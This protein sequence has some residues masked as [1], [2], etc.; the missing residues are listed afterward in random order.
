MNK[1]HEKL[2]L[3]TNTD[4]IG[5]MA[6]SG[7]V[8][9][10]SAPFRERRWVGLLKF[11]VDIM[12]LEMSLCLGY[13]LRQAFSSLFP[14]SRTQGDFL[15]LSLGMLIVPIGYWLVR[16]YPGYGLTAVERL[17]RR[18]RATFVMFVVCIAWEYLVAKAG[19][20]SGVF[21]ATFVFAL[22]L[23]PIL[24]GLVRNLL[25]RMNCWGSPVLVFGGAKTGEVVLSF[26]RNDISLGL[27]PVGVID[28]DQDKWGTSLEGVPVIGGVEC[29]HSYVDSV[30]Y[31]ILAMPGAGRERLVSLASALPFPHI[32][33]IPDL[34]G[35]PSLWVEVRDL[36]GTMGLQIK[37]DL[38][39]RHNCY[40]KR[41]MDFIL[42][43][44]LFI[45][46]LPILA[47]FALWIKV[48]S[49]GPA[50]FTQEREGYEGKLF[51]IWKLRT[52]YLDAEERLEGYLAKN[53][54]A[55][56]EWNR[57]Y[58]LKNDPRI[59]P[60]VGTILRKTSLD[61]LPQLWNILKGEMSLVGPRPF[62]KYHLDNFSNEF[63]SM[64]RSVMPGLTGLWQVSARSDGDLDIQESLDSYYIRNWSIWMD[65]YLLGRT[66][67][68]V[69]TGRGAY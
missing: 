63:C 31:A 24:Q 46:S 27:K 51:R 10:E 11:L 14:I 35:L 36:G 2:T 56:N 57:F 33:I 54:A 16:L 20:S 37:K 25:I 9:K 42:G 64:R 21:L 68:I 48:A 39:L 34:L 7:V 60:M 13:E 23:P 65:L 47:F 43:I 28:D 38:L 4:C 67:G 50:F 61:E 59:L 44:P 49:P 41:L 22:I 17:R 69:L 26:L 32:I 8:C 18:V 3:P 19:W 45:I 30:H 15:H 53:S 5:E 62:P 52:M 6:I 12:A 66:V 1:H 29:I 55:R 40:L 58:K